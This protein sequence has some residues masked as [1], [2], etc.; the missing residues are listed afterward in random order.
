MCAGFKEQ[1]EGQHKHRKAPSKEEALRGA[2][3]LSKETDPGC[4]KGKDKERE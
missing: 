4:L 2:I 1:K 3:S